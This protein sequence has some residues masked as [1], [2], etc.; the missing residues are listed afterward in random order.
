MM[1]V[2]THQRTAAELEARQLLFAPDA[3]VAPLDDGLA[4]KSKPRSLFRDRILASA[5]ILSR[6]GERFVGAVRIVVDPARIDVHSIEIPVVCQNL[7]PRLDDGR[8][9]CDG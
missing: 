4:T 7:I 9:A 3:R 2:Q 5:Q 8:A 6:I 1:P